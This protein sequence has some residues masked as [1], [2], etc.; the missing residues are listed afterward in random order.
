MSMSVHVLHADNEWRFDPVDE[1]WALITHNRR[2]VAP[3]ELWPANAERALKE[4]EPCPF[5][6]SAPP[7]GPLSRLGDDGEH[8]VLA[9]PSPTALCFVEHGPPPS[10]PFS[11][12]GALGAHEVLVPAGTVHHGARLADTDPAALALLFELALRRLAE[13]SG[14][15]RLAAARVAF[16]PPQVARLQH[17]HAT[18]LA[19]PHPYM[20]RDPCPVCDDIEQARAH[21]RVVLEHEGVV[22]WAPF[23][24]RS[25][26]HV[27]VAIAGHG[28]LLSGEPAHV[29]TASLSRRI[30]EVAG[31]LSRLAPGAEPQVASGPLPLQTHDGHLVLDVEIPGAS[32]ALLGQS[33][34]A[35]IVTIA[36]EGLA[37]RLRTALAAKA[38]GSVPVG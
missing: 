37:G 29:A 15:R 22:V 6:A 7:A 25:D 20:P 16:L 24:P 21:G 1:R 30:R 13:L 3:L 18:L 32:D 2:T 36:P 11:R 38:D 12:S 19:T 35:S 8:T 33:L 31:G 14:D 23:A 28:M 17:V 5:C 10:T 27:R 34:G 26:L 4:H 9:Y